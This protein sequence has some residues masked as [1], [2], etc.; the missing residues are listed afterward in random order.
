[1]IASVV[2][3]DTP[4]LPTNALL[5]LSLLEETPFYIK[6]IVEQ[7]VYKRQR[8]RLP[9]EEGNCLRGQ[10]RRIENPLSASESDICFRCH[11]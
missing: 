2:L 3:D 1:M 11:Y 7:D 10:G 8:L 6:K 4:I 9:S 5:D